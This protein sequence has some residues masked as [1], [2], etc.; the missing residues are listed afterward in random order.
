NLP[1]ILR[2]GADW[3]RELGTDESPG[4]VVCTVSG[5]TA[6]SGVAEVELGTT[7]REVIEQMGGG[8]RPGRELVAALS[9][10]ANPVLP[11]SAFDTPLSYEA[12]RAAGSGLGAAGF[13]VF[14]D[15]SDLVGVGA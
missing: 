9:G 15:S 5:D 10:V 7:L 13:I 11:A 3:F 2:N 8:A 6:R 1:G 4:T 12:M 14:D